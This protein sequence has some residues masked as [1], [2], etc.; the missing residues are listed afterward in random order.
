MAKPAEALPEEPR[1]RVE[2]GAFPVGS[3]ERP[4]EEPPEKALGAL[5]TKALGDIEAA[6]SQ[7]GTYA[8]TEGAGDIAKA[9][10]KETLQAKKEIHKATVEAKTA[11]GLEGEDD[12]EEWEEVEDDEWQE[13]SDEEIS[14]EPEPT[15]EEID[16]KEAEFFEGLDRDVQAA[17]KELHRLD[18][19]KRRTGREDTE[20]IK[21]MQ[22]VITVATSLQRSPGAIRRL[23][24]NLLRNISLDTLQTQI[25]KEVAA[26]DARIDVDPALATAFASALLF[27]MP[28]VESYEERV[29]PFE[30][31]PEGGG[32]LEPEKPATEKKEGATEGMKQRMKNVAVGGAALGVAGVFGLGKITE[33]IGK[34]LERFGKTLE[35][36]SEPTSLKK[37]I[38]AVAD[39]PLDALDWMLDK[40]G[41]GKHKK[42]KSH[43]D[44]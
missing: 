41:S 28:F 33:W 3:A 27:R 15:E 6:A 14:V 1:K 13:V 2:S 11:I 16:A 24:E 44:D 8:E 10:Q 35:K 20:R 38:K 9:I 7:A 25:V 23:A 29:G 22:R 37:V 30:K 17:Q 39:A 26:A 43:H 5:E 19:E 12:D 36:L 34:G 18:D 42:G 4:A 31:K 32:P 40:L 21:A